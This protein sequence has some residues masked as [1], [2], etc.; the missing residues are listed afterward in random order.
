MRTFI[1]F[2]A[3]LIP[4]AVYAADRSESHP[5]FYTCSQAADCTV[6]HA[7]CGGWRVVNKV[8][9][10]DAEKYFQYENMRMNCVNFS[11]EQPSY[12]GCNKGKCEIKPDAHGCLLHHSGTRDSLKEAPCC[13]ACEVR[14]DGF[15]GNQ[16]KST[17]ACKYAE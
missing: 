9:A 5:E 14:T 7:E 2:A 11:T 13:I 6:V 4:F 15:C 17:G 3:L 10:S 16:P 12:I 8:K 1:L